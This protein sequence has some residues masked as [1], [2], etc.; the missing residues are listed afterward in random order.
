[1][2]KIPGLPKFGTNPPPKKTTNNQMKKSSS[3][4]KTVAKQGRPPTPLAPNKP[5]MKKKGDKK[6][7]ETKF[8]A[9]NATNVEIIK[10]YFNSISPAL[11]ST[12][13]S[14]G[15]YQLYQYEA[16]EREIF[17]IPDQMSRYVRELS[18]NLPI[19]HAGI[20][21]GFMRRKKTHT[22]F[23]RA[24]FLS[25]EGGE[26]L[27]HYIQNHIPELFTNLQVAKLDQ[28]GE[29]GFLYGRNL[30]MRHVMGDHDHLQK[31]KLIFVQNQDGRFLGLALLMVKQAGS[32]KITDDGP[33]KRQNR[34]SRSQNF[35]LTLL[36]LADAGQYFRRTA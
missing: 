13:A 5:S 2:G 22:G 30:E 19:A 10:E 33:E 6:F 1:M 32:S 23:E 31:K 17:L 16:E 9:L 34:Y 21:L 4:W 25:Y 11:F 7:R 3:P 12:L 18:K 24:F 29:K 36:N 8:V 35:V 27:F 20:H 28:E 26:F 14:T 15:N